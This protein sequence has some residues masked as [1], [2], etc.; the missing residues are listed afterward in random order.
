M[1]HRSAICLNQADKY[2]N[3][4]EPQDMSASTYETPRVTSSVL[5][6]S[7]GSTVYRKCLYIME[8]KRFFFAVACVCV[9]VYQMF[10]WFM[11]ILLCGWLQHKGADIAC[12]FEPQGTDPWQ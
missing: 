8:Y 2:S 12:L 6:I 4:V 11:N 1:V 10:L 7:Q 5:L 3:T 9:H